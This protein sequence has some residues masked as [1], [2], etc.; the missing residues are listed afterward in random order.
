MI[1]CKR[2]DSH[3]ENVV[4]IGWKTSQSHVHSDS[5]QHIGFQVQYR[6]SEFIIIYFKLNSSSISNNQITK[7]LAI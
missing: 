1:V 6:S 4:T 7:W 5:E 2:Q 3:W